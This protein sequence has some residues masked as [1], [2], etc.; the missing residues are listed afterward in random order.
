LPGKPDSSESRDISTMPIDNDTS[1]SALVSDSMIPCPICQAP[2]AFAY[3]HPDASIFRCGDCR[4]AFTYLGSVESLETYDTSYYDDE[5]KNWFEN[6]NLPLFR[7]IAKT[8]PPNAESVIDV[9]CGRGDFLRYMK[10]RRPGLALYGVDLSDNEN[11]PGITFIRGDILTTPLKGTYD[12][13]VSL[14]TIE[15]VPDI[16]AFTSRLA[17]LCAPGGQVIIMTINEGGIVYT[18]A[19]LAKQLGL[20]IAFDR[21]YSTHHLHH[22]TLTSLRRLFERTGLK[23][24]NTHLHNSSLASVDVPAGNWL[25]RGVLVAAVGF[26]YFLGDLTHQQVQQTLVATPVS[27][28]SPN[29]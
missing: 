17:G 18:A 28:P 13:V 22:F 16:S 5:H 21:L 8:I 15:H 4:H 2:A 7:W 11:E 29:P 25:V 23:I 19:R 9:G 3:D 26:L 10:D 6:P 1:V 24:R 27:L 14:G 20:T 12:V